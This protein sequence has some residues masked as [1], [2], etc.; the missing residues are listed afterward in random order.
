MTHQTKVLEANRH[1]MKVLYRRV[2]AGTGAKFLVVLGCIVYTVG[3]V[4]AATGLRLLTA[5]KRA[6]QCR[7]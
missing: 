3:A 2:G 5:D 6:S 7:S 1:K 4:V